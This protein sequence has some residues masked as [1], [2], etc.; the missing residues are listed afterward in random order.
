MKFAQIKPF[1]IEMI[2]FVFAVSM[3][4][5]AL[6]SGKILEIHFHVH[7]LIVVALLVVLI[8]L[9][10]LFSRIVTTGI[11]VL[12]DY[13]LQTTTTIQAEFVAEHPYRASIFAEENTREGVKTFG[14][15]YLIQL[16]KE[17]QI[18]TILAPV[19]VE[20]KEGVRY[21]VTFGRTSRVFLASTEYCA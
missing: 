8:S 16:K 17:D 13:L 19:F 12:V 4:F 7:L 11:K 6:L 21:T 5:I 15:Y 9:I 14:M 20:F 3:I 10:S 18:F 1:V 2:T